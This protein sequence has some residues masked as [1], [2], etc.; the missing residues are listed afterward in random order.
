MQHTQKKNLGNNPTEKKNTT[1]KKKS[2]ERKFPQQKKKKEKDQKRKKNASGSADRLGPRYLLFG[3]C[4]F[5][6]FFRKNERETE[7]RERNE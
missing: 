3:F 6:S 4:L 5:R 2:S 7:K 1:K